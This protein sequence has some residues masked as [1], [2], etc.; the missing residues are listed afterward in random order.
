M[1]AILSSDL[2]S[3]GGYKDE[4]TIIPWGLVYRV[5]PKLDDEN[6]TTL[7]NNWQPKS[8]F[9]MTKVRQQMKN[10][11]SSNVLK[12]SW[13]FAA[14]SVFWDMH[15]QLGL[16]ILGVAL[17]MST[18]IKEDKDLFP[19]YLLSLR[20]SSKI[21]SQVADANDKQKGILK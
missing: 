16:H 20:A 19:V 18:A 11:V 6:F 13:E 21:L 9:Q 15:Y 8:L 5:V 7:R 10:H 1:Q 14:L 4:F 2:Q 3:G 12:G 17:S